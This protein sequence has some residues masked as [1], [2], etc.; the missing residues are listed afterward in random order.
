MGIFK[1]CWVGNIM[2]VKVFSLVITICLLAVPTQGQRPNGEEKLMRE[3]RKRL[4]RSDKSV[5]PV[6]NP[7]DALEVKHGISLQMIKN[8]DLEQQSVDLVIWENYEFQNRYLTWD[9]D[10]YDGVESVRIPPGDMFMPDITP[11]NLLAESERLFQSNVV[12]YSDSTVSYVPTVN[13]RVNFGVLDQG[14]NTMMATLKFGSW[15][16]DGSRLNLTS[17][18]DQVDTSTYTAHTLY[19]LVSAQAKRNV[20]VYECCPE[21]YIDITYNMVFRK[22][23]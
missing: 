7:S 12:V 14:D 20:L 8:I 1:R 6:E 11:Y 5:R 17:Q 22:R 2:G 23:G 4:S 10:D 9:S 21:P 16:Y 18:S 19:E 15:T 3:L 13:F